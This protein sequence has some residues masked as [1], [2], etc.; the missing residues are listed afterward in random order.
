MNKN[1]KKRKNRKKIYK[2]KKE[3]NQG[4]KNNKKIKGKWKFHKQLMID[5]P[6]MRFQRFNKK[7]RRKQMNLELLKGSKILLIDI[8]SI[9]W[10]NL[11][12]ESV[13]WFKLRMLRIKW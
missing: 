10:T 3:L 5:M 1:W 4:K 9:N 7:K 11:L 12:P 8:K 13:E 6:L 2:K